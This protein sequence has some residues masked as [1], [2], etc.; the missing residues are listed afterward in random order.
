V[1]PGGG[2]GSAWMLDGGGVQDGAAGTAG[3]WTGGGGGTAR[4]G[5][6][7]GGRGGASPKKDPGWARAAP[8][9]NDAVTTANR[10][11]R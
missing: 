2:N 9:A 10:A 1:V 5:M 8:G 4:L 6:S 3:Y 7:A 11:T